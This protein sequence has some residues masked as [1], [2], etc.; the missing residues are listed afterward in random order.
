M[1]QFPDLVRYLHGQ[2]NR[3]SDVCQLGASHGKDVDVRVRMYWA[4]YTFNVEG[5]TH[6]QPYH[7]RVEKDQQSDVIIVQASSNVSL[8][9]KAKKEAI[10]PR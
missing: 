9:L 2:P 5:V 4:A 8:S 6:P 7:V 1:R 10:L 3:S